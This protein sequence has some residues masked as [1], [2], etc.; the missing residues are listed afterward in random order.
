MDN[1][2][3]TSPAAWRREKGFRLFVVLTASIVLAESLIMLLL[4]FFLVISPLAEMLLDIGLLTLVAGALTY[5]L[6]YKE[7]LKDLAARAEAEENLRALTG[8]LEG[9]VRVRTAKFASSSAEIRSILEST[10]DGILRIDTKGTVQT[11][12]RSA[13]R[14]LGYR[15]ME[16]VGQN[17]SAIIPDAHL[18]ILVEGYIAF[19]G[20]WAGDAASD[21]IE[22]AAIKKGG[23]T[24]PVEITISECI[25]DQKI[26]YVLIMRDTTERKKTMDLLVA[27][28]KALAAAQSIAHLGSWEMDVHTGKIICSDELHRIYGFEPGVSEPTLNTFMGFVHPDDRKI[29][30]DGI[31]DILS[32]KIPHFEFD[33]R[34]IRPDGQERV[35]HAKFEVIAGADGKPVKLTGTNMDIT[36]RKA[37]VDKL[38][39]AKEEAEAATVLK[40]KF[41]SLVSHDLK[42]P[43]GTMLGFMQIIQ[44][45]EAER[46]SPESREGLRYAIESGRKMAALIDDLLHLGR[47]RSGKI[48][49]RFRFIDACAAVNK[50]LAQCGQSAAQ[51]EIA[52][53]NEVPRGSRIYADET[54]I[55]EVFYNLLSNAIKFSRA[56]DAVTVSMAGESPPAICVADNG[57]GIPPE[58][59]EHLFSYEKKT[60][61]P[62]TNNETG[63]GLGLPLSNEIIAAHGGT[64]TLRSEPGKGSS[65]LVTLP[66]NQRPRIL[67]VDDEPAEMALLKQ[68]LAPLGS[69]LLE[70]RDGEGAL[71]L[72]R[73][74]GRIDLVVSNI[75]MPAV[76]GLDLVMR[77]KEDKN[78]RYIPVIMLTSD[79]SM[80]TREKALS[81][82]A[83]DFST[84]PVDTN[85]LLP[86][87]RRFIG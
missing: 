69:D 38:K 58:R 30:E 7:L 19:L 33:I 82:G 71:R 80:E 20:G 26:Y 53:K 43:L 49:P 55:A 83:D 50:A 2:G 46:I 6:F 17:I 47:V 35:L 73:G 3:E 15:G 57:A 5:V 31:P 23:G 4:Q 70:A 21:T 66:L 34:I 77:M 86:R 39:A 24:I 63:S 52:V 27:H 78:L 36:D 22:A 59:A 13:H 1:P 8:S 32:G 62:G 44:H 56:G 9:Q 51:K 85:D 75:W 68:Y 42:G 64:L 72:L 76:N 28:E 12:N 11:A 40:D 81:L 10:A 87:I 84:K 14:I 16:L 67:L 48:V 45:K 18:K 41:V 61:T 65:F 54:L 60:S 25:I 79:D 74:G 37:A 29:I